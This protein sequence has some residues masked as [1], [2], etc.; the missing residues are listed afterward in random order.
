MY[1]SVSACVCMMYTSVSA[2]VCMMYMSVSAC[3]CMMYMYMHKDV[4][5][6]SSLELVVM[7][8]FLLHFSHK[9]VYMYMYVHVSSFP[10]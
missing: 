10:V 7:F 3:V 6:R 5:D 8:I 1:M 9:I 2:C 4:P